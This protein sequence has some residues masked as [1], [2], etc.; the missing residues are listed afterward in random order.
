MKDI[1]AIKGRRYI[2]SLIAEGEHEQQDFKFMISDARKIARSISAFSNHNGGRLLI[3]VKDNGTV[4]GIRN[5]E[6]IYVVESAASI[7]CRPEVEITFTAFRVD[8]SV[9]VIKADIPPA[10][11]RP[12][13]VVEDG[14]EMKAYFRV[15][16][17]NIA[18]PYMLTLA[19]QMEASADDN[20]IA[21]SKHHH[22]LIDMIAEHGAVSL[23]EFIAATHLPTSTAT[24]IAAQL[25]SSSSIGIT[26]HSSRQ[27]L[28]CEAPLTRDARP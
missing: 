20:V 4:A 7:Y 18:A 8:P 3:G 9:V 11:Q 2:S 6:D 28:L 21:M 24:A 27:W 12:V 23:K 1:P 19:W 26:Y 25:L 13:K 10:K 17:E 14:G 16:D 5:E 15:K 22:A